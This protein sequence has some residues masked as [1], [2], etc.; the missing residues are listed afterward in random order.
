[1]LFQFALQPCKSNAAIINGSVFIC[2][3]FAL[4]FFVGLR[5]R[6]VGLLCAAIIFK[7]IKG[8]LVRVFKMLTDM[9]RLLNTLL[10][11]GEQSD[12]GC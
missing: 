11:A 2:C 10:G 7:G 5:L 1:M 8:V 3:S 9:Y 4:F 12:A 6:I